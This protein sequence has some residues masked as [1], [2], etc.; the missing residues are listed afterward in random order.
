MA[1]MTW[2]LWLGFWALVALGSW[3]LGIW[4]G[5]QQIRRKRYRHFVTKRKAR[6]QDAR[7]VIHYTLENIDW[8]LTDVLQKKYP[9]TEVVSVSATNSYELPTGCNIHAHIGSCCTASRN[10]TLYYL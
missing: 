8:Q 2:E 3:N 7:E 10:S 6:Q 5:K 4:I 1:N 9:L